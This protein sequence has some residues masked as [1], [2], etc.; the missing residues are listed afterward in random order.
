MWKRVAMVIVVA[1]RLPRQRRRRP[2]SVPVGRQVRR[3]RPSTAPHIAS[4][5]KIPRRQPPRQPGERHPAGDDDVH[6]GYGAVVRADRRSVAGEEVVDER[7][8]GELRSAT[9]ASPT[10]PTGR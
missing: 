9:R 4:R 5:H 2:C 3:R 7:V 1:L 10:S 8:P 6:G